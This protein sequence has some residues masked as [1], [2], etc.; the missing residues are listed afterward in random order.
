MAVVTEA[1]EEEAVRIGG[2]GYVVVGTAI[3]LWHGKRPLQHTETVCRRDRVALH[4]PAHRGADLPCK[5][6]ASSLKRGDPKLGIRLVVLGILGDRK[7]E[8][9]N[10]PPFGK[11]PLGHFSGGFGLLAL[12]GA[13]NEV[14]LLVVGSGGGDATDALRPCVKI[15]FGGRDGDRDHAKLDTR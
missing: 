15:P 8:D 6:E 4:H 2:G 1:A 3:G 13:E 9:G 14:G 11:F 5:G 12:V 7:A 10:L